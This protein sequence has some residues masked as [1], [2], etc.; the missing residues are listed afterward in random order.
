MRQLIVAVIGVLLGL[1]V[2]QPAH[3]VIDGTDSTKHYAIIAPLFLGT[4]GAGG[5]QSFIRLFNGKVT[6]SSTFTVTVV[7]EPS[8]RVMGNALTIPVPKLSSIQYSIQEI[9]SFAS[10]GSFTAGDTNY[11]LYI[12]NSDAEAGYQHAVYDWS[13]NYFENASNCTSTI[14]EQML[15]LHNALV[16]P[17]VHTSKAGGGNFPSTI[18]VHNY[19]P[20]A[21]NYELDIYHAGD[22]VQGSANTFISNSGK[23]TCGYQTGSIAAN[24][25]R[26]FTFQT[27]I[28]TTTDCAIDS[29]QTYANIVVTNLSG[30]P[31]NATV[32]HNIRVSAFNGVSNFSAVC[33]VNKVANQQVTA[34]TKFQGSISG[35]NGQ[36]G[37]FSVTVPI[38]ASASASASTGSPAPNVA[39]HSSIAKAQAIAVAGSLVLSGSTIPLTGTYDASNN[40]LIVSGGGFTFTGTVA[41]G[42]YFGNYTGP[43]NASGGFTALNGTQNTVTA[44]CGTW[45][46]ADSGQ[47]NVTIAGNVLLGVAYGEQTTLLLGQVTGSSFSGQTGSGSVSFSGTIQGQTL[48]A[49]YINEEN[50]PGTFTATACA[51]P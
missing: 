39:T 45:R 30:G 19:G 10:S 48:N 27:N 47:L 13:N 17:S 29:D 41:G 8:G 21:A 6:G 46:D 25:S 28:E 23:H 36:S 5:S 4:Q 9:T 20:V 24:A 37:T 40:A 35:L 15:A 34:T 11:A 2:V 44:Y 38:S 49:T 33:A 12:Q 31:P 1:L 50:V 26:A 22:H 43:N 32:Q 16:I 14:N 18:I 7:G 3:A 42:T 51:V